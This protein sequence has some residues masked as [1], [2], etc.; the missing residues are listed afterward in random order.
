MVFARIEGWLDR[1]FGKGH[2]IGIATTESAAHSK[3]PMV[4]ALW[5]ASH[6]GTWADHGVR[7]FTPWGWTDEMWEV[8]HLFSRY[9]GT[10]RISTSTTGEPLV[11]AYASVAADGKALTV[12][13][14]NRDTVA[15][16]AE[17]AV[18]NFNVGKGPVTTLALAGVPANTLTFKSHRRNALRRGT[19]RLAGGRVRAALRP[20]SITA[21]LIPAR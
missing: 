10:V 6:L 13:L 7:V 12:F 11:S 2:G 8:L 4:R 14:V 21:L 18:E 9:A 3:D 16:D 17:V 15:R 20:R 5:Y 1:Y 19:A